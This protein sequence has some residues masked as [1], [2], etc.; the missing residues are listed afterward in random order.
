[1]QAK[2]KK[3]ERRKLMLNL[4]VISRNFRL[5]FEAVQSGDR[6]LQE[7]FTLEWLSAFHFLKK[8][9]YVDV[10]LAAVESE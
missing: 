9:N 5:F 8:R 6:M 10:C 4:I 7:H 2:E 3:D 1:M